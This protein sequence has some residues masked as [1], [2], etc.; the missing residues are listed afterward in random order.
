M[1]DRSKSMTDIKDAKGPFANYDESLVAA[2]AKATSI[3][4][5][6]VDDPSVVVSL[7][8]F[9]DIRQDG[10]T[11][12]PDLRY[13]AEKAAAD[14]AMEKFDDFF[15]EAKA[16]D[17][18]RNYGDAWTYVAASI[19]Q[20]VEDRY[21]LGDPCAPPVPSDNT[22]ALT[23]LALTDGGDD[24]AG[25]G[26]SAP[27]MKQDPARFAWNIENERHKGWLA[28]QDLTN[29]L[30]YT[31]WFV[32]K[33]SVTLAGAAAPVYRVQWVAKD[34]GAFNMRDP[35]LDLAQKLA[36]FEPR[37][38]LIPE[39]AAPSEAWRAAHPELVCAPRA[40]KAPAATV[41]GARA[42]D[43]Q[44]SWRTLQGAAR[45]LLL[46]GVSL[47][48]DA[49]PTAK[50]GYKL[51]TQRLD[52]VGNLV[53]HL[54]AD[55]RGSLAMGSHTLQLER[56]SLCEALQD[57]Y[58]DSTFRLPPDLGATAAGTSGCAAPPRSPPG[59]LSLASIATVSL[60][61]REVV[62]S[63]AFDVSAEGGAVNAPVRLGVDRWWR[64]T[65]DVK[66]LFRVSPRGA[67]P[68]AWSWSAR[69]DVLRDG[70]VLDQFGDVAAF[71]GSN[72]LEGLQP[73]GV[74]PLSF[75]GKVQ[76]WWRLGGDFPVGEDGGALEA[77][78]CFSVDAE[79]PQP[80]EVTLGTQSGEGLGSDGAASAC[81]TV[82]VEVEKRPLGSWWRVGALS[83]FVALMVWVA[84][85]WMFRARFP[86]GFTVGTLRVQ[87]AA[88]DRSG[89]RGLFLAQ[90]SA[91]FLSQQ[92]AV[93]YLDISPQERGV[94]RRVYPHP[95]G[96]YCLGLRPRKGGARPLVWAAMLPEG[97][98]LDV[99]GIG[100]L[101][102]TRACPLKPMDDVCVVLIDDCS[103]SVTL[104]DTTTHLAELQVRGSVT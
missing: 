51:G 39:G 34:R 33:D 79:D 48:W 22:A 27:T 77:R 62:N 20:I 13:V 72:L 9:G 28:R 45:N 91:T 89:D 30:S 100:S 80:H 59:G 1:L 75:P 21:H 36:D 23:I 70:K 46:D 87:K 103:L 78:V 47:T 95:R 54:P 67:A 60:A 16:P 76:R 71:D 93:V 55:A 40:A 32:A 14:D 3:L 88:E 4:A 10:A 83:A 38:R 68:P 104:N 86:P 25:G 2:R 66:R 17:G 24:G 102:S 98:T 94:C 29:A 65:G 74:A 58:P 63:Y 61:D 41:V 19:H 26:E 7:V 15:L 92:G 31:H 12:T 69:V 35:K 101:K 64:A 73:S 57:A 82:P 42:V 50:G 18:Q 37:I 6:Y 97:A 84:Q 81:L 52:L 11:W 5:P 53:L 96:A 49:R 85:R 90:L 8:H 43:V 44:A 56:E 99:S